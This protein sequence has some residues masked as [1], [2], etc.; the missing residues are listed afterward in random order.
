MKR[1]AGALLVG[2]IG[3]NRPADT[4]PTPQPSLTVRITGHEFQ[5]LIRYAGADG[6]IDTEDDVLTRQHL[7]LPAETTITID[8]RSDDYVYTL[9][10]PHLDWI[11]AAVPGAPLTLAFDSGVPATHE[12]RGSQMCGFTHPQLIGAVVVQERT[13]FAGWLAERTRER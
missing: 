11:E 4:A 9:Y 1:L 10:L 7:H 6:V 12:L 8:L 13:A 5:W 2:L 3:C